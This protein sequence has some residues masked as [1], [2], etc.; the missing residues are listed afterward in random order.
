[1]SRPSEQGKQDPF[2]TLSE[3]AKQREGGRQWERKA[4][5]RL[6][7]R[8]LADEMETLKSEMEDLKQR[9]IA[10]Q[11]LLYE[12]SRGKRVTFQDELS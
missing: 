1:L 11:P 12:R 3:R 2:L 8:E 10:L 9:V 4:A 6:L 5:T 7:K